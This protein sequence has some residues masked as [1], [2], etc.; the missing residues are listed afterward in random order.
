MDGQ[1][2]V[3]R[4]PILRAVDISKQFGGVRA[5]DEVSLDLVAGEVHALV[6]ENGAGKSTLIKVLGGLLQPTSG[7]VEV[8]GR[9]VV[10]ENPL[11]S[12]A[13][14]ISVIWQEFNLVPQLTVAENIFLGHEPVLRSGLIDRRNMIVQAVAILD[15]LGVN[16]SPT[17]RVEYLTVADKQLVEIA[18][19]L[20]HE[21][22]VM[23]MDEPTAALNAGEVARLFT[24]IDSLRQRGTA[25]LY[26][27]HRLNE[28]FRLAHRVTVF[29][30][31]RRVTTLPIAACTERSVIEMMLGRKIEEQVVKHQEPTAGEAPVL[32]VRGL[33]RPGILENVSFDL[34]RGEI[35]GLA[36]LVGAGRAELMRILF[37]MVPHWNGEIRLNGRSV[38]FHGPGEALKA[39]VYMLPE[40]RRSEGLLPHLTVLENL[41]I[42]GVGENDAARGTFINRASERRSYDRIRAFLSIRARSPQDPV[43][44]LSGGNQQKVLFGRALL[45][46]CSVLLLNEP[47]R[48]VDVGAKME[49]HRLITDLAQQGIAVLVS[50]SELPELLKLSDRCLVLSAGRLAGALVGDQISEDNIMA[51]AMGHALVGVG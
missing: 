1:E 49:I 50:S 43:L 9:A 14:G 47:T 28:I 2:D 40:D 6:G 10:F 5:L 38:R 11:Q 44:S 15:Q 13:A 34:R 21:F 45:G 12:Q 24:I 36:G 30:D 19:A 48:G 37:G 26:V 3:T 35:V 31:G 22:R 27:S 32:S 41:V 33:T 51:C 29:R 20:S 17:Q 18:K 46:K 8:D 42:G 16:I 7:T 4:R 25:V 23:I 39:G